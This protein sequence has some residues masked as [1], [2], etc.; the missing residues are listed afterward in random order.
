MMGCLM[1]LRLCVIEV[2]CVRVN[3]LDLTVDASNICLA[4]N[5][6]NLQ[7]CIVQQYTIT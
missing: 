6:S 5:R 7:L 3:V 2:N 4:K 1:E